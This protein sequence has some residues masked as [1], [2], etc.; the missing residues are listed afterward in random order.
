M[1]YTLP[2]PGHPIAGRVAQNVEIPAMPLIA[3][4]TNERGVQLVDAIPPIQNL[5]LNLSIGLCLLM[6]KEVL[7]MMKRKKG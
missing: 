7:M 1:A 2:E 6:K 4:A 3:N 5:E